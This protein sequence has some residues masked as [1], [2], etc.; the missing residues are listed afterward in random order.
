MKI[1]DLFGLSF[2]V[3]LVRVGENEVQNEESGLNEVVGVA[4]P[5]AQVLPVNGAIQSPGIEVVN[6]GVIG[7]LSRTKVFG[8]VGFG[9]ET[10]AKPPFCT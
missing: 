7:T 5:V 4:P 9:C 1:G 6:L 3:A 8:F 10:E 2:Q